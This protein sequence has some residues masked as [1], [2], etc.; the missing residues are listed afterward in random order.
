MSRKERTIF[1]TIIAN[2]LLILLRFFLAWIS[3][4]IG[5]RANAWHSLTDVFVSV[6]VFAS[7]MFA[8]FGA[9]KWNKKISRLEN[10][11]AVF[12][13]IF[14]FYMGVEILSDA[15]SGESA[16]LKYVPFVAAGAFCGVIINYFMARYKIYVGEQTGSQSLVADGYH[17]K[18]DMYCSVAVLIGIVGSLFGMNSLDKMA[19]IV[20]MVLLVISGY[21]IFISNIKILLHPHQEHEMIHNHASGHGNKKLY[22]G[23]TTT[24]IVAYL[25]SGVYIVRW[26][27][28]GIARRFGKVIS[29]NVTPGIHYR[30]PAPIDEVTLIKK[31]NVQKMETGSLELLS[32]DTNLININ[33]TIHYQIED[34]SAY[35][36]NVTGLDN[37]VQAGAVTSIREIVGRS[38]V[39]YLLT[40]GKE[41]VEQEVKGILQQVLDTN[42]TGIDILGVQLIEVEPPEAVKTSFQDLAS[43]RQDKSVYINEATAYKNTIIPQANAEAYKQITEAEGYMQDKINS[44]EGEAELF[45]QRQSAYSESKEVTEIRLYMETM[46]RIL[47]EVKKVLLGGNIS[48]DNTR[49]WIPDKNNNSLQEEQ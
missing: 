21:E 26:D 25:L 38:P 19:A 6:V 45:Q 9:D 7:L 46:E 1:I 8:R 47:P 39:D 27:E 3:G 34:V 11:M 14:I 41:S 22:A 40:E 37:L 30:L 4:S 33:M 23:I 10:I 5:L 12:V 16:E 20:A 29:D 15:L 13:S 42:K 28:I 36:L 44:A 43:A 35:S 18:M 17:S 49:L 31:D 24:L 32:G 2:V 48:I